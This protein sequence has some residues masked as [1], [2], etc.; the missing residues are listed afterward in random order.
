[1]NELFET[2]L[3]SSLVKL[4]Y[5]VLAV[6]KPC[7][8][9]AAQMFDEA[10]FNDHIFNAAITISAH[11]CERNLSEKKLAYSVAF[12]FKLN[13]VVPYEVEGATAP[14]TMMYALCNLLLQLAIN[15]SPI[16]GAHASKFR[17]VV[18]EYVRY[19]ESVYST[20]LTCINCDGIHHDEPCP[21]IK[22]SFLNP[23]KYPSKRDKQVKRDDGRPN[24][25]MP[26]SSIG[27]PPLFPFDMIHLG[28]E[29]ADDAD[30]ITPEVKATLSGAFHIF[31]PLIGTDGIVK[32][33]DWEKSPARAV[34]KFM[35]LTESTMGRQSFYSRT[36]MEKVLDDYDEL[37]REYHD[38]LDE[39]AAAKAQVK[40]L[41]E[42]AKIKIKYI[43]SRM[44]DPGDAFD[45]TENDA[46]DK[47]DD[48]E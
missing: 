11:T 30:G 3:A 10:K 45:E 31:Y 41:S 22:Y 15:D 17:S 28:D 1:M 13:K 43:E 4:V 25:K 24:I 48:E 27:F 14:E 19:K 7:L 33:D 23:P 42:K 46:D 29:K 40:F 35:L 12:W 18:D 39:L 38:T 21:A 47:G 5:D 37:R 32:A 34:Q 44:V 26:K 2:I 6:R 16:S 9:K 36:L 8:L 20:P